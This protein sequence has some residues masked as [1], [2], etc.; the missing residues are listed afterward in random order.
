MTANSAAI[1]PK[2]AMNMDNKTLHWATIE[3]KGIKYSHSY[4]VLYARPIVLANNF[5]DIII[6]LRNPWG[7][8]TRGDQWLGDWGPNDDL[9]TKHT[10]KQ[11]SQEL[12]MISDQT[13]WMSLGDFIDMFKSITINYADLQYATRIIPAD[14]NQPGMVDDDNEDGWGVIHIR[15]KMNSPHAF[16][17]IC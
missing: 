16:L 11:I 2:L 12:R 5:T 1:P 3:G 8:D 14:I 10:K 13:F 4:T 15:L 9:W 17:R 7:K 6:L